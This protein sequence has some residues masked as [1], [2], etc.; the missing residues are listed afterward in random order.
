METVVHVETEKLALSTKKRCTGIVRQLMIRNIVIQQCWQSAPHGSPAALIQL[1][2]LC[3]VTL[4]I[5][6]AP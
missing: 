4:A 3:H 1:R 5:F 2:R 6:W